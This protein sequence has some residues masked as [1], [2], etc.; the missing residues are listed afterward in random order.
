MARAF[1]VALSTP[2]A[3][4]T[5]LAA[6]AAPAAAVAATEATFATITTTEAALATTDALA[7]RAGARVRPS[8]RGSS[9]QGRESEDKLGVHLGGLNMCRE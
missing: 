6:V 3:L 8:L 2:W 7:A 5:T 9:G 1:T 4:A